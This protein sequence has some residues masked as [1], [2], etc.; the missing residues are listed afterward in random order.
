MSESGKLVKKVEGLLASD[1]KTGKINQMPKAMPNQLV[2]FEDNG[3][4][5]L[6]WLVS[7]EG[8][9]L[10]CGPSQAEIWCACKVVATSVCRKTEGTLIHIERD[11]KETVM[12]HKVISILPTTVTELP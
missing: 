3:Q 11:G 6:H 1:I 10:D 5:F 12:K 4:D 8:E 7:P 2:E 9:I